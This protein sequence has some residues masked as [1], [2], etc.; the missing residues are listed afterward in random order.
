MAEKDNFVS[1]LRVNLK[2]PKQCTHGLQR[3]LLVKF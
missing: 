1:K 2:Y 3:E